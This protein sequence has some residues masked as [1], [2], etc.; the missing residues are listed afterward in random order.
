M[1]KKCSIYDI[2]YPHILSPEVQAERHSS[3]VGCP[4][5]AFLVMQLVKNRQMPF[6]HLAHL[7]EQQQQG[8]R[9]YAGE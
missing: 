3:S 5:F 1:A 6:K 8:R 2:L 4:F 7:E 9:K